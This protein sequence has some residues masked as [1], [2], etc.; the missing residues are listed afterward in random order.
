MTAATS[1]LTRFQRILLGT[2]GTVTHILEAFADEPIE[3]VKLDQRLDGPTDA[4]AALDV[5]RDARV[6]RRQVVLR[7]RRSK[8]VLLYAEAVIAPDR[9]P[10]ELLSGLLDTDKPIGRLLAEHR[11]ET[12]REV[13]VVDREPAGLCAVH[14]D[15]DADAEL[16]FRTYRIL[17]RGAPIM[18]ITEKFPADSF[19]GLPG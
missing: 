7:T 13:L 15:G 11:L 4:D 9:L 16:I 12:F 1:L 10:L 6:L 5:P 19:R 3:V 17:S 14:F 2:D 18:L 8:A